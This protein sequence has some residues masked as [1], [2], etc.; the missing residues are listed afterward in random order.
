RRLLET[1]RSEYERSCGPLGTG[2]EALDFEEM[3]AEDAAH[4]TADPAERRYVAAPGDRRY[5]AVG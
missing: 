2:T 4:V 5:A 1:A 3:E